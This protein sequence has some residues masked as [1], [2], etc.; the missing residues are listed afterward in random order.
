MKIARLAF[1]VT[2]SAL[3]FP[4]AA[5]DATNATGVWQSESGITRVRVSQ[6]G[7]ALCGV[8]V[9]Q[10]NPGK[11]VHNPD[12][13]KRDRP[14]VGLQLVSGMKQTA[15]DEWTGSIYNYEDGKT[16]SGKVKLAGAASLQIGGCV[17]GGIICQTRTWRKVQ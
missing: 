17:M 2:L 14:I 12:P 9:W 11:D 8:V 6:C 7:N 5:Q 3:V 1:A 15:P 10:K 4:A 16:Y 13:A